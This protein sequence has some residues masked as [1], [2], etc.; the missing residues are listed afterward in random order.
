MFPEITSALAITAEIKSVYL[1]GDMTLPETRVR[2]I[3]FNLKRIAS[4]TGS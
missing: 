4:E 1:D 2:L 3:L